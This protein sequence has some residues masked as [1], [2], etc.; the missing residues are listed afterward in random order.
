MRR[1][2]GKTRFHACVASRACL[3]DGRCVCEGKA[4][5]ELGVCVCVRVKRRGLINRVKGRHVPTPPSRDF[6]A[7]LRQRG[8]LSW[9][10]T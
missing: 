4:W 8:R 9:S 7:L 5:H 6:D 10:V 3:G 1:E 2:T